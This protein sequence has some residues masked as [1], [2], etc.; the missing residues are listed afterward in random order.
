MPKVR[1]T[2][3]AFLEDR[4]GIQFADVVNDPEKKNGDALCSSV[5]KRQN[6]QTCPACSLDWHS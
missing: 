1:V 2:R 3:D 5:V 4:Q 6:V